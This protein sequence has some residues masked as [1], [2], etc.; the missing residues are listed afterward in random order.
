MNK[1]DVTEEE[2]CSSN[3]SLYTI[4]EMK[5]ALD[6]DEYGNCKDLKLCNDI[7]YE[8]VNPENPTHGGIIVEKD[9][10]DHRIR[11]AFLK[12]SFDGLIVQIIGDSYDYDFFSIFSEIG[13]SIGI[14]IGMSCM[15]IVEFLIDAKKCFSK[16]YK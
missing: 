9:R 1:N 16:L 13:G 2:V 4:R 12:F 11:K 6:L 10:S 5:I 3:V 15:T 8:L 14:L 7:V